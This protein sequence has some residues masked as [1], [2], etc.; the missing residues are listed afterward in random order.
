MPRRPG[1]S[2]T[3][4]ERGRT[5]QLELPLPPRLNRSRG[6]TGQWLRFWGW[7]LL[8]AAVADLAK[9]S[10]WLL[11]ATWRDQLPY[12]ETPATDL[13]FVGAGIVICSALPVL[14]VTLRKAWMCLRTLFP[15]D[16]DQAWLLPSPALFADEPPDEPPEFRRCGVPV[17]PRRPSPLGAHARPELVLN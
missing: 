9:L 17:G 15:C 16:P 2:I 12:R 14:S 13:Y 6:R 7:L 5:L 10:I 4:D 3:H 1:I 8:S 11:I